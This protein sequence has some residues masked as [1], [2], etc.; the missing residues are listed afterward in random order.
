M[1]SQSFSGAA[2]HAVPR[3][4][5]PDASDLAAGSAPANDR[6]AST[7]SDSTLNASHHTPVMDQVN[8]K[9]GSP[10]SGTLH[11][12]DDEPLY[13]R[14]WSDPELAPLRKQ[15]FKVVI[16][17]LFLTIL[18]ALSVLRCERATKSAEVLSIYWG[19]LWRPSVQTHKLQGA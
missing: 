13:S 17:G 8:E 11:D 19:A 2:S 18:T 9:A 6:A 14:R 1:A 16:P 12:E 15:Y 10:T 5:N 7:G 3:G 4:R